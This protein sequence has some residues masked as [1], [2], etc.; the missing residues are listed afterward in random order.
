VAPFC[1]PSKVLNSTTDIAQSVVATSER[2]SSNVK[3]DSCDQSL[4]DGPHFVASS[5]EPPSVPSPVT[6]AIKLSATENL[7]ATTRLLTQHL[8]SQIQAKEVECQLL[9]DEVI[10][11][12]DKIKRATNSTKLTRTPSC[13]VDVATM[14]VN[15]AVP[16]KLDS[17][18]LQNSEHIEGV[19][20]STVSSEAHRSHS[21]DVVL[22]RTLQDEIARLA[23]EVTLACQRNEVS[24]L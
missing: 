16:C 6:K 14:I 12:R 3:S 18:P 20:N 2:R 11:L 15:E 13:L 19:R 7:S 22:L 24:I 23:K 4:T 21:P 1:E 5:I 9:R 8:A 17:T 10:S